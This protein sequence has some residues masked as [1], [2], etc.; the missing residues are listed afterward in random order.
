MIRLIEIHGKD[1]EDNE[2][3]TGA[4][5][6]R[7]YG[8]PDMGNTRTSFIERSNLTLRMSNARFA[9]R[10]NTH[11]KKIESH[12]LTLGLHFFVYNF[13]RKHLSLK[14]TPAMAARVTDHAWSMG[15]LL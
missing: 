13:C 1:K 5:K 15:D 9:R 4:R 12:E 8:A 10:S 11:S 3:C 14:Q 2:V 7:V 6:E